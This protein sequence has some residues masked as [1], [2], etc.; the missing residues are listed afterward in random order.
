MVWASINASRKNV[1]WPGRPTREREGARRAVKYPFAFCKAKKY[2]SDALSLH[3]WAKPARQVCHLAKNLRMVDEILAT[4]V[5]AI[6]SR[7]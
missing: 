6:R 2:L 1:V 3:E 7:D 5:T 4:H